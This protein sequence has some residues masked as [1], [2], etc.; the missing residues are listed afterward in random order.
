MSITMIGLDTAKSVFQ[1]H[2][3]NE[4][5]KVEIRRKLRRS[6]LIPFFEKQEACTVVM[7]ACGAAHHWARVLIGL[8]HDVK[9]IAPEAVRPFV[10]KGK[11]NDPADA[12]AL[13]EAGGRPD[14]K[15]VPVK[16][17]EQQAVLAVHSVRALLVKQQTMLSNALRGL[18]AEF[19]LIVPKGIDK[20]VELMAFV[21][22][23]ECVPEQARQAGRELL[24][25]RKAVGERIE[26]LE[27][28]IVAHARQ[29]K[30]ARRLATIPGVGPIAGSAEPRDGKVCSQV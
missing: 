3:V 29:D 26:T 19:G 14:I 4:T 13:C 17:E 21:D 11:K 28:E 18:A 16:T 23:N 5:G 8:G 22:A 15:F 24:D 6:E 9:L 2:G 1:V 27:A 25:Q 12:A 10:K 30:A 7:E 20:L